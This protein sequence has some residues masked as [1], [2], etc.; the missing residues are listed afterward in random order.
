MGKLDKYN[1]DDDEEDIASALRGSKPLDENSDETSYESINEIISL[2]EDNDVQ[3]V[4]I[5]LQIHNI[6]NIISCK[7]CVFATNNV[8]NIVY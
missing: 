6:C 2:Y 8:A 3:N 4:L 7:Y 5:M 1:N